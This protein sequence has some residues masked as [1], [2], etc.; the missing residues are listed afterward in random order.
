ML[1]RML[2]HLREKFPAIP[3]IQKIEENEYLLLVGDKKMIVKDLDPGASL[4]TLLCGFPEEKREELLIFLMKANFLGQGTGG[5]V[6]GMTPDEKALTLSFTMPY[7]VNYEIFKERLEDFVNYV[8]YW[9][10]KIRETV[11]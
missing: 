1:E 11:A 7:E 6:L 8:D 9:R 3:E 5:S 4:I 2:N 10:A